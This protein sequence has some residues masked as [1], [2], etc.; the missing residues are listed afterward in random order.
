M[1]YQSE[2]QLEKHLIEQLVRQGYEKITINDYDSVL[3]NFRVQLNRF[4]EK[5]L[6]GQQLTDIEFNRFLLQIDGKS[7]F[8]SSKI[9][10]N[11]Q[12]FQR[13]DGTEVYLELFNTREWCKN[14]FQVT[15][16]TTVEGKYK[17]RYDVTLLINGLPIVQVE[18]KRRG[19]DFKEAF[20]QIQRYRRH[21]FRGLFRFLQL[22]VVSNGVDTKYFANSDSDILFGYTFFWSDIENK[23]IA[24]LSEF[25]T[26]FLEK[27]HMAKMIARYMV[28]NETEKQLMVMRPYQVYAVEALVKRALETKNNGYIWHTTGSGKTLTSFKA[29][30]ILANEPHIKKVFFLI[31]RKDLDSQTLAEFNKF[32]PGSVDMTDETKTLVEQIQDVMKPLI[33]TTIQKMTHAVKG[34]KY[35]DIMKPYQNERVIII[36]D[37]CHRSQFGKMHR[38]IAN[39]FKQAQYF[40]FTGTPL[41]EV[42]KSQDGRVTADIFEKCLHTYLIKDAIHDR[43]V[44]GFS[45]EYIKTAELKLEED[46]KTRVHGIMTDEVWLHEDRLRLV[47]QNILENHE[48]RAR[49]KGYTALFSVSGIPM[50][51]KYYDMF[52]SLNHNFR[53]AA[54]FTYGQNEDSE[55]KDEHSR[56]SLERMITDYNQ[57]YGTNFST[58]KYQGYFADVS[59]KVK[60]AQIDI[61]LVVNIF[62]TGFDS[63]T[64]NTL[65]L[66]RNLK[67]HNLIQAYSRTNRVEKETKPYGIIVNY[68]NLKEETDNAIRLFSQTNQIDDVLMN[69][70]DEYLTQFQESLSKV[71]AQAETP[72]AVDELRREEQ[73]QEFIVNFR[74]LTKYLTRLQ[75]FNDFEFDAEKLG[76]EEQTYQ[77]FK[78]KYL[79]IYEETKKNQDKDS[80]LGN[81]DFA[82]ELMHTDRINVSYIM[83]LI[84]NINFDDEDERDQSIKKIEDELSRADN[85]E[86]RLKVELIKKF[87]QQVAPTLTNADSVDDT[88]NEFEQQQRTK[89]IEGFAYDTGI[90]KDVLRDFVEEYEYSGFIKQQEISDSVKLPFLQKKKLIHKTIEFIAEHTQRYS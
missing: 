31:D 53:I 4:N 65:Y 29:S 27:C 15:H 12:V 49:S 69:S 86:L 55:G 84:R 46:D 43:N 81:I 39:H 24:T 80:I 5:K 79:R 9:L 47:A 33:V 62:L 3:H 23:R 6:N 44:L 48:R 74:E 11:K 83:N 68:R 41:F 42:N 75:T 35:A 34:E 76:I 64:L 73:K 25:A 30:Q 61:L 58:D 14:I 19:L 71:L 89:E 90:S 7:I 40:G 72:S 63:K 21:S 8:D 51:V 56:D 1:T 59:R 52:K 18:L 88:F 2:G 16:Q 70:Y 57:M 13:D 60:T 78:S 36:I 66:D 17:N 20:N 22:F 37:E 50:L 87:L 85:E 38:L 54:I 26:T 67:H 45:V 10:R 77:D 28:L 32:E 82:I